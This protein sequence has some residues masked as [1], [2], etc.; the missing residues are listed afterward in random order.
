[1]ANKKARVLH[2][3]TIGEVE[4]KC[5][6]VIEA[7]AA[8]IKELVKQGY[9]D[10]SAES[11]KYCIDNEGAKPIFHKSSQDKK[12]QA[13]AEAIAAIEQEIAA[14]EE[15]LA[16]AAEADKPAIQQALE[17]KQAEHAAL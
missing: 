14:L 3:Q 16:V 8:L 4:Y 11:V 1:M 2:N 6:Q 9:V 15:Q 5:N 17:A 12:A 13:K 7:D 10:D